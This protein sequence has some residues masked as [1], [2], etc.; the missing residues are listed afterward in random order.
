MEEFTYCSLSPGVLLGKIALV[1]PE[2]RREWRRRQSA[3]ANEA[4]SELLKQ[5]GARQTEISRS[6]SGA[7]LFPEG[8]VGS[9]SHCSLEETRS[10]VSVLVARERFVKE[11]LAG[12][13]VEPANSEERIR[14]LSRKIFSDDEQELLSSS[15]LPYP[16]T[17]GFSA[18]ETI[19]KALFPSYQRWFSFE[20]ARIERICEKS[21][22][23]RVEDG[24]RRACNCGP[25]ITVHGEVMTVA[26]DHALHRVVR[27]F[28]YQR[29]LQSV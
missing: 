4:A 20:K 11:S 3:A 10:F 19:F 29:H 8:Y 23:L 5:L 18:K 14:P 6:A 17:F 7:P 25:Y 16:L 28:T 1:H 21:L 15:S 27:T 22:S 12:I 2:Q 26:G 9:I 13:D 24:I